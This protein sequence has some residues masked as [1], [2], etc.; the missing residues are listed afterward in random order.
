MRGLVV[1]FMVACAP[2]LVGVM[3]TEIGT[4]DQFVAS[5]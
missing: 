2:A 1:A 3:G 4:E 5:D